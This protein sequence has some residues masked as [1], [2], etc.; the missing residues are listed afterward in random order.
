MRFGRSVAKQ[1]R[2]RCHRLRHTQH[3]NSGARRYFSLSFLHFENYRAPRRGCFATHCSRTGRFFT[4]L[5]SFAAPRH[6]RGDSRRHS[7]LSGHLVLSTRASLFVRR[8]LRASGDTRG[9]AS[10]HRVRCAAGGTLPERAT[11]RFLLDSGMA[12]LDEDY[13]IGE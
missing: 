10:K 3:N 8:A 12:T 6:C 4:R 5:W 11:D 2:R 9:A 13:E 1:Q 7:I